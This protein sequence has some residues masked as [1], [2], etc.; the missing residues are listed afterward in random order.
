MATGNELIP[1]LVI[2]LIV[3]LIMT[4]LWLLFASINN[5][6]VD[7]R[8]KGSKLEAHPL[9]LLIWFYL[10]AFFL[11]LIHLYERKA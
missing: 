9:Q 11:A 5:R 8:G 6:V 2:S 7:Q 10:L 4:G 3:P 1:E